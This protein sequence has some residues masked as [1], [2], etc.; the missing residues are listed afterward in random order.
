MALTAGEFNRVDAAD[1][2][3]GGRD[4]MQ[5]PRHQCRRADA[6]KNRGGAQQRQ[7]T[8]GDKN[9]QRQAR[10]KQDQGRMP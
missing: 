7:F 5:S 9:G 10:G 1:V 6:D 8:E 3:T 4:M 2:F